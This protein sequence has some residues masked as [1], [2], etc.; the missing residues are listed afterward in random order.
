LLALVQ[1]DARALVDQLA[2]ALEVRVAERKLLL[3]VVGGVRGGRDHKAH[4]GLGSAG[5]RPPKGITWTAVSRKP[6]AAGRRKKLANNLLIR[7]ETALGPLLD[8]IAT[9]S[10]AH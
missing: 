5:A 9:W 3:Q 4:G 1:A 7:L 2:H 10:E 6:G 8:C